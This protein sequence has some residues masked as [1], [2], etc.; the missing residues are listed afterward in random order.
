VV[1]GGGFDG[2]ENDGAL[3]ED[4][5]VQ[6]D[7]VVPQGTPCQRRPLR[8]HPN[9]GTGCAKGD[10]VGGA[11]QKGPLGVAACRCVGV[12]LVRG[13]GSPLLFPPRCL[14]PPR[15]AE[16]WEGGGG[17]KWIYGY[18]DYK[19]MKHMLIVPT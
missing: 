16:P 17:I 14:L 18:H 12:N 15:F 9:K 13:S 6:H 10:V 19:R 4:S 5:E 8:E 11:G 7:V 3:D 1:D 2:D